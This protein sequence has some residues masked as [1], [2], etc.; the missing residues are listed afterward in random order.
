M[1][2]NRRLIVFLLVSV[3]VTVIAA[4]SAYPWIGRA[5]FHYGNWCADRAKKKASIAE[6]REANDHYESLRKPSLTENQAV[7][8]MKTRGCLPNEDRDF[9][10]TVEYYAY[11]GSEVVISQLVTNLR[12]ETELSLPEETEGSDTV[13][14]RDVKGKSYSILLNRHGVLKS[15]APALHIELHRRAPNETSAHMAYLLITLIV[16][17]EQLVPRSDYDVLYRGGGGVYHDIDWYTAELVHKDVMAC[18]QV[19]HRFQS[20]PTIR[21]VVKSYL[22]HYPGDWLDWEVVKRCLYLAE[23]EGPDIAYGQFVQLSA[24]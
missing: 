16:S 18:L 2:T 23:M 11:H 17:N 19:Y 15:L 3:A 8:A 21:D 5:Y 14:L 6:V 7:E 9:L 20:W 1:R 22:Y 12:D 13:F 4:Y 10:R 24:Q